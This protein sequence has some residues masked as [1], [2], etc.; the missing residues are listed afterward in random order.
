MSTE[1]LTTEEIGAL[2]ACFPELSWMKEKDWQEVAAF[3]VWR[4]SFDEMALNEEP[5]P[6]NWPD[7]AGILQRL[8]KTRRLR[9]ALRAD[10]RAY[11]GQENVPNVND[12][13]DSTWA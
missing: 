1:P 11:F 9:R 2:T 12:P 6:E 3:A 4:S 8:L 13:Q 7:Y 10:C 5:R